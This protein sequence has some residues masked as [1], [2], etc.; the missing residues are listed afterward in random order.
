MSFGLMRV[1]CAAE[2]TT[3]WPTMR[4]VRLSGATESFGIGNSVNHSRTTCAIG[5][6][7]P[8]LI[9]SVPGCRWPNI[10]AAATWAR[11][12][13]FLSVCK[14]NCEGGFS[15][16]GIF[17]LF[18]C[19][20]LS[21]FCFASNA[22]EIEKFGNSF[23]TFDLP[24]RVSDRTPIVWSATRVP[25]QP[26]VHPSL[27]EP[28]FFDFPLKIFPGSCDTF[29][30]RSQHGRKHCGRYKPLAANLRAIDTFTRLL[31]TVEKCLPR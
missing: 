21:G 10:P 24:V 14:D 31:E 16:C 9:T 26:M 4:P 17:D 19:A 25:I 8:F 29:D 7:C 28:L 18:T 1:T 23:T 11:V 13:L 20:M 2:T 22:S 30:N 3:V 5:R 27:C 15:H 6:L 12:T